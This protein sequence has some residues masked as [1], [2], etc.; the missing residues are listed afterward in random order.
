MEFEVPESL[1]GF[2][3]SGIEDLAAAEQAALDE[4]RAIRE[5]VEDAAD[6]T[7]AQLDRLDVLGDFVEGVSTELERR[8]AEAEQRRERAERA[9]ARI[10]PPADSTDP[11]PA[12]DP[13]PGDG[14]GEEQPVELGDGEEAG[15]ED[16]SDADPATRA[17]AAASTPRRRTSAIRRMQSSS[18]QPESP[19]SQ[20][21]ITAAAGVRG[22][23]GGQRLPGLDEVVKAFQN[24]SRSFPGGGEQLVENQYLRHSVAQFSRG[25]MYGLRDDQEQYRNDGQAL[26]DTAG[27]EDN[28]RQRTGAESLAAAGGWCAPSQTLYDLVADESAEGLI[29]IPEIGVT[30]GGIRFT[31]GPDF[32]TIYAGVGFAQ[33]EAQAIAGTSKTCYEVACPSFS[34]VRLDAVGICIKAPLLTNAAY[35]ELVRR[36]LSGG[37]IA[38][39]HKVS[40]RVIAAMATALGTA[41][42]ITSAGS[43]A[44]NV[45]TSLELAAEYLRAARRYPLNTTM[46]VVIPA[47][48]RPVLRD[49]LQ[50]RNGQDPASPVTDA[51]LDAHFAAR[52]LRV[53]YVYGYDDTT[54]LTTQNAGADTLQTLMPDTVNAMI[55]PAGVFVKGTSDVISLDTVYDTTDLQ[56]NVYTAMFFEEGVLVAKRAPGGGRVTIPIPSGGVTGPQTANLYPNVP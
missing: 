24:R 11:D 42:T 48:I 31:P 35:P 55:Y 44:R 50:Y 43:A 16:E 30:R 10:A 14:E 28:L 53:Q 51:Q 1:E 19:T 32:A 8:E 20:V 37:M 25:D 29:D 9:Q 2:D 39:Q 4:A 27:S 36:V 56:T 12:P 47:W 15:S 7:D 33:T 46:E 17:V 54:F 45:L 21:V 40:A 6:L 34:E 5:S 49:D 22:Y 13:E 52:K 38:H 18:P 26:V 3:Y 41:L 23:E